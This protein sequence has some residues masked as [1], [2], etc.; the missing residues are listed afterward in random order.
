M[1]FAVCG[2]REKMVSAAFMRKYIHVAKIIK[3]VLTQESA[4]YIAE[5]YSCL[6]SQDSMGSDT[7]RVSLPVGR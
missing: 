7:A 6:R 5:E 4:A 1:K 2:S 3:P